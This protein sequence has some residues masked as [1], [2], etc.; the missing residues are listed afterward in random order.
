MVLLQSCCRVVAEFCRV[1]QS[2]CRVLLW[3]A[4][5]CKEVECS[6]GILSLYQC[7]VVCCSVMR[8]VAQCCS[9]D[10]VP[11]YCTHACPSFSFSLECTA[12]CCRVVQS[13][14][15]RCNVQYVTY[16]Y[17]FFSRTHTPGMIYG[18]TKREGSLPHLSHTHMGL[19]PQASTYM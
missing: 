17:L 3:V 18:W 16:M 10:V 9:A 12:E 5:S 15:V 13:F 8:C 11:K 6:S 4:V 14:A 2:C 7:V 1:L 19:Y